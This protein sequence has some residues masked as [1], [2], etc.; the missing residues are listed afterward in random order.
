MLTLPPL[1]PLPS[2]GGGGEG[3][4]KG[5]GK[6]GRATAAAAAAAAAAARKRGD[7][8][9]LHLCHYSFQEGHL[10]VPPS[11]PFSFPPTLPALEM[12]AL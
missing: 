11:L 12:A 2:P 8:V 7:R 9:S 3:G 10:P 4:G 1:F 5:V 6:A